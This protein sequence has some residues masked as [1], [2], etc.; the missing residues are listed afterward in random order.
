MTA[1]STLHGPATP[2]DPNPG[3]HGYRGFDGVVALD[4]AKGRYSVGKGGWTPAQGSWA[5][6]WTGTTDSDYIWVA[7]QNGN[8]H[9]QS[10]MTWTDGLVDANGHNG[11]G[12]VV[13]AAVAAAASFAGV[14]LF[15]T[16]YGMQTLSDAAP[17]TA[18]GPKPAPPPP[19]APMAVPNPFQL[20]KSGGAVGRK[21]QR[22]APAKLSAPLR[23]ATSGPR[24]AGSAA[25]SWAIPSRTKPVVPTASAASTTSRT[26]PSTGPRARE[27]GRSMA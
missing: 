23:S 27:P 17:A 26:A 20:R 16:E 12:G 7:A 22:H 14:D 1:T 3:S 5:G 25:H 8:S 4:V 15:K 2:D 21:R 9:D 18:A 24:S 13:A 10:R 19:V 11:D 6:G